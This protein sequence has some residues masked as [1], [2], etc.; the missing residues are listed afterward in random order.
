[1]NTPNKLT[2]ARMIAT[3]VFMVIMLFAF[4]YHYVAALLIFVAASLTDLIDGKLARKYNLITDFGKFLDPL[5]DK[6][7]TT[8]AYLG[9]IF[10]YADKPVY[11]WQITAITFVVLFREFA[12]SSIRLVVVSSGG[13]VIA[14]NMWGK[15]KTVSQMVGI[16]TALTVFA[17]KDVF[18]CLSNFDCIFDIVIITLFWV[19]AVLCII[20]GIIYLSGSKEYINSSK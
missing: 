2:L 20:S 8:A 3:P 18:R 14:A 12:V 13:K 19:S 15:A 17:A 6:M 16:S 7:L 5:A 4:P 10:V 9:F 11:C 1:M